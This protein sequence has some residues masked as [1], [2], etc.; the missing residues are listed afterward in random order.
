M[1]L[2]E[3][4]LK[5]QRGLR[6]TTFIGFHTM[7]ADQIIIGR[8]LNLREL[9]AWALQVIREIAPPQQLRGRL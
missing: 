5:P 1:D 2:T 9:L 6:Q 3:M 8:F 7:H 4:N